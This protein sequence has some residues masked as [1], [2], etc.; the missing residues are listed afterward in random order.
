MRA[1]DANNLE[2]EV[3]FDK[4][5]AFFRNFPQELRQEGTLLGGSSG[6]VGLS[7]IVK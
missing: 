7:E 4:E 6:L 1:Y 2:K 3:R 5:V